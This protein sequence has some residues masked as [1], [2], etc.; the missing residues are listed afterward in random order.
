[1][2]DFQELMSMDL[3]SNH[4]SE[5][6]YER[7]EWAQLNNEQAGDY[8]AGQLSFNTQTRKSDNIVYAESVLILPMRITLAE[9]KNL[10]VKNSILSLIQGVQID[11]VSGS[12]LVSANQSAPIINNLK[13]LIDSSTDFYDQNELMFA[14]HDKYIKA[15][16]LYGGVEPSVT[17]GHAT[18]DPLHNP[19]LASRICVFESLA[20]PAVAVT[21]DGVTT[22]SRTLVAYIPL[23]FLSDLFAQLNFPIQN[24]GLKFTFNIAGVSGF[25][26]YF[27]FTCP[28]LAA[29]RTLGDIDATTALPVGGGNVPGTLAEAV[30]AVAKPLLAIAGNATYGTGGWTAQPCIYLKTVSFTPND[31]E[32]L[33]SKIMAGYKKKLTYAVSD[34]FPLGQTTAQ[35]RQII[36]TSSIRPTRIWAFPLPKGTLSSEANTFPARIGPYGLKDCNIV[37]GGKPFY[38]NSL[39]TQYELYREFKQQMMGDGVSKHRASP[40]SFSDWTNGFNPYCFDIS[41]SPLVKTNQ[42]HEITIEADA[43]DLVTGLPVTVYD[44]CVVVERLRTVVIDVSAGGV[45]VA[46]RDG[47]D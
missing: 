44:L 23:K 15:P 20:S 10:A 26:N 14:G 35:F 17:R 3:E 5:R 36:T 18:I 8:N 25:S 37:L 16:G 32:A 6:T 29:H 1:M 47:A 7:V 2:S 46:V 45:A 34:H 31:A 41:R 30:P 21:V 22:Y 9:N 40:I 24:F 28:S 11:S 19:A 38:A 13:L 43:F 39:R 42:S 4:V 27:P 33:A 12:S